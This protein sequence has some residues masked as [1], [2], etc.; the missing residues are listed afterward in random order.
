MRMTSL[1]LRHGS[2]IWTPARHGL[3]RRR[4]ANQPARP[5]PPRSTALVAHAP[6]ETLANR[7]PPT[8]F[9][10]SRRSL[11]TLSGRYASRSARQS[12]FL[13]FLPLFFFAD[14]FYL[15]SSLVLNSRPLRTPADLPSYARLSAFP[16]YDCTVHRS[17]LL[18]VPV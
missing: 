2:A 3:V 5:L 11:L 18:L 7:L 12:T 16:R 9:R 4:R 1:A 13:S 8:P 10:A 17:Q 14:P 15:P 6:C